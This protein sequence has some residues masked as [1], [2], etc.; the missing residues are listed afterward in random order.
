MPHSPVW[1]APTL[2]GMPPSDI[3]V[4]RMSGWFAKIMSLAENFCMHTVAAE[5]DNH[6]KDKVLFGKVALAAKWDEFTKKSGPE[7][8]KA[9]RL[10]KTF[11]WMLTDAQKEMLQQVVR[12]AVLAA[13]G[14]CLQKSMALKDGSAE[15]GE[16]G[17]APTP[18]ALTDG[19]GPGNGSEVALAEASGASSSGCPQVVADAAK[20]SPSAGSKGGGVS[21]KGKKRNVPVSD[22]ETQRQTLLALLKRPKVT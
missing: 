10:L 8:E 20:P 4:H 12:S 3:G 1:R 6:G 17:G 14:R 22:Q 18:L 7:Q 11:S 15:V 13:R 9:T 16:G 19:G 2:P 5:H 21:A